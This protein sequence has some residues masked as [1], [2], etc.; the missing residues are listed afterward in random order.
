MKFFISIVLLVLVDTAMYF[1]VPLEVRKENRWAATPFVG[2]LILGTEYHF[3]SKLR[4]C[5]DNGSNE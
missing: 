1:S 5:G 3:G 4:S 2:G